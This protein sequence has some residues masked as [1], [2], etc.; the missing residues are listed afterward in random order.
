MKLLKKRYAPL[1]LLFIILVFAAGLRFAGISWDE[2]HHV[3]PDERFLSMIVADLKWPEFNQYFNFNST[4]NPYVKNPFF[5]YGTFPLH[6]TKFVGDVTNYKGYDKYII[7]GRI[8]SGLFDIF[9]IVAIFLVALELFDKK[10][11]LLSAFLLAVTVIHIQHS[12]FFIVDLFSSFFIVLA[13]YFL[14]LFIKTEKITFAILLGVSF[15]FAVAA[16]VSAV[17]LSIVIVIGCI[18]VSIKRVHSKRISAK[19][20]NIKFILKSAGKFFIISFLIVLVG[21]VI[22]RISHPYAFQGPNIWNIKLSDSFVKS[23]REV[24]NEY[25]PESRFPPAYYWR[26]QSPLFQFKNLALWGLGIPLSILCWA[27]LLLGFYK[28]IVKKELKLLLPLSWV[29]LILIIMSLQFAKHSRYLLP[30]TPF[31][32]MFGAYALAQFIDGKTIFK[33]QKLKKLRIFVAIILILGVVLWT[34]AFTHIYFGRHPR[35]AASEWI[36]D[37]LPLNSTIAN[38]HWDDGLPFYPPAGRFN[39]ETLALY[40]EDT[41]EKI[42]R[43]GEQLSKIDYV[44][45][46]SNRLYGSITRLPEFWPLTNKYYELLFSG[47]LGYVLEKEFTNYPSL[48]GITINDDAAEES[49]A[50]Y[51]HPK[52]LVFKNLHQFNSTEISNL[53]RGAS[54]EKN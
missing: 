31:I 17:F 22:F 45:I 4:I 12:H 39:I 38:E 51:D 23:L 46:T 48:F 36:L 25:T 35:A 53:I 52:V 43:L 34:S 16:K 13:F 24:S 3:H 5:V 20:V 9:T 29:I 26:N 41:D 11:A 18:L 47:K 10:T 7:I 40:N 44:F 33:A 54:L 32:V 28:L 30:A 50:V 14:L 37:T 2:G 49:F 27:G 19:N 1:V 15:G 21:F 42:D 8:L 6:L